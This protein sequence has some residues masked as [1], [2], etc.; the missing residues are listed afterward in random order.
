MPAEY[1]ALNG[2]STLPGPG[3]RVCLGRRSEVKP[4][5]EEKN[6]EMSSGHYKVILITCAKPDYL[7]SLP[8]A[9]AVEGKN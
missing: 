3:L 1:S 7:T 9:H 2:T 6:C 5:A 4:E 8:G